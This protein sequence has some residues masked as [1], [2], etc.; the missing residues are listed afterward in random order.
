M[1]LSH[2]P[3]RRSFLAASA[4]ASAAAGLMVHSSV[5]ATEDTHVLRLGVVGCGGRGT[6]AVDDSLTAN[7]YVRLVAA[8]DPYP[9]KAN[10]L[11]A[12]LLEKH[13]DKIA[14]DDARIHGGL[15]GY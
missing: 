5:A 6:G 15:D 12:T 11:R 2:R 9:G 1:D 13:A 8:A 10:W 4:T 3:S 7:K 14:L